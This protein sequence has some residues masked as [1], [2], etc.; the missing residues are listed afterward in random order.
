MQREYMNE[1]LI[2][3]EDCYVGLF[4]VLSPI[5]VAGIFGR[6]ITE[7]QHEAVAAGPAWAA[8]YY[9]NDRWRDAATRGEIV[10]WALVFDGVFR[11][12]A[13]V[14]ERPPEPTSGLAH[15]PALMDP[16][17]HL[18]TCPSGRI[19]VASLHELG[20]PTLEPLL[21]IAPGTYHVVVRQDDEQENAHY[22]LTDPAEYPPQDG[23]DWSIYVWR[24]V[25]GSDRRGAVQGSSR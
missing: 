12:T 20:N 5:N 9:F 25:A 17:D 10:W 3:T 7:A 24:H 22:F 21:V 23:P 14:L 2:R 4:D 16:T 11:A 13:T 15:P 18:L 1:R 6:F 8:L 19:V